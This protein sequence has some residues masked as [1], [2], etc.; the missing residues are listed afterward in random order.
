MKC[1][2]TGGAGFIGSHLVRKLLERGYETA[3]LDHRKPAHDVEWMRT[4][5]LREDTIRLKGFD[6]VYHLAALSNARRCSQ[7]PRLAYELNVI[8]TLNLVRAALRDGVGRVLLA[9]SAWVA[10]AQEGDAVDEASPFDVARINTIYAASKLSQELVLY[11]HLAE[12]GGPNF[13]IFRY[14]TPYGE[15]M[16]K[17]LVIREFMAAAESKGVITVLGDGKQYREF[18]YVGDMCDAQVLA[19]NDIATNRI[20]NLTGDRPVTVEQLAQEVAKHFPAQIRHLPQ[21]R[22]EPEP[23]RILNDRAKSKLGWTPSTTLAE[24]I[25]RCAAWWRSLPEDQK[26]G[27]YWG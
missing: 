20:Y 27:Q 26:R 21:T 12:A 8:G 10:A 6:A 11:S 9:S 2:V 1:L 17:G 3:V 13:T 5:I 22:A 7:D 14:G 24:G 18:L 23:R 15:G 16:W 19:L 4:D 25:A